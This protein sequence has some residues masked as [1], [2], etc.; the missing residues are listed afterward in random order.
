[1]RYPKRATI[2]GSLTVQVQGDEG[3]QPV[4]AQALE[5]VPVVLERGLVE[6][7]RRGLDA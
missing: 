2:C 4:L 7:A 5:H 3:G 1:M 6:L